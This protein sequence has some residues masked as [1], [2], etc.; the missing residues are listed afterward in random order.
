MNLGKLQ[1]PHCNLTATSLEIM[2]NE[3]YPLLITLIQVREIVLFTQIAKVHQ[4]PWF[5]VLMIDWPLLS[6]LDMFDRVVI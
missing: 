1:Q 6:L 5:R 3:G 2:V 4:S